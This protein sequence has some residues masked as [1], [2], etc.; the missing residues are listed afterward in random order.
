MFDDND[1]ETIMVQTQGGP[2]DDLLRL[3]VHT[4]EIDNE[5]VKGVLA[6]VLTAFA[7]NLVTQLTPTHNVAKFVVHNG[8][9]DTVN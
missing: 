4:A 8:G 5:F 7:A 3:A 1:E 2:I 9:K 6:E